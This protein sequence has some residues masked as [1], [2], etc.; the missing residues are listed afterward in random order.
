MRFQFLSKFVPIFLCLVVLDCFPFLSSRAFA[1]GVVSASPG[2]AANESSIVTIE[3]AQALVNL[4]PA[5]KDLRAKGM[6]VKWVVQTV[7]DMNNKDYCFFWIYN[8]TAQGQ[9]D[10]GSISVGTMP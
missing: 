9:R 3:D 10:I 4:L 6:V 8:A 2:R 7:P 5:T 1:S